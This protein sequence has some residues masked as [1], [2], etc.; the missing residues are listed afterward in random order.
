[1]STTGPDTAEPRC[2]HCGERI[3]PGRA[4]G[5]WTH[6]ARI[7]AACDLDA[8]HRP[9]PAPRDAPAPERPET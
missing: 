4:P 1:M 3:M 9:E 7:V 6:R 2:A 5:T 8:D